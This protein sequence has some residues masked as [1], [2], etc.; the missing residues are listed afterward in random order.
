MPVTERDID[1]LIAELR[2]CEGPCGN[3]CLHCEA[4]YIIQDIIDVIEFLR[5]DRDQW[6]KKC[7]A[8]ETGKTN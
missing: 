1:V 2:E 8:K 7:E 3:L 6:K 4:A 5:D